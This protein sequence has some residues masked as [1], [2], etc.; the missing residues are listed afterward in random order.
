[1]IKKFK[2]YNE[3]LKDKM[4]GKSED[5]ILSKYLDADN[6]P[7]LLLDSIRNNFLRGFEVALK[8]MESNYDEELKKEWLGYALMK[9]VSF[10][11][12]DF[13]KKSIELGADVNINLG[14]PLLDACT[15][16]Y[17]KIVETLLKN[18]ANPHIRHDEAIEDCEANAYGNPDEE[19]KKEYVEILK[20]L[21]QYGGVTESLRDKMTPKS[22]E[23]V[24]TKRLEIYNE[25]VDR[26]M[27]EGYTSEKE[28]VMEFFSDRW[29]DM[30]E[31]A[32][33]GWTVEEIYNQLQ[34]DLEYWCADDDD[35]D[36]W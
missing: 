1:M 4:V 12:L 3:S 10:H 32:E 11:R 7:G 13:V 6:I 19:A 2:Q 29:D 17:V 25:L 27:T 16:G 26:G 21:K 20:L 31:M 22:D 28:V 30:I 9:A 15:M 34:M 33:E 23:Y 24:E 5:E 35:D 8:Y 14:K 36:D 18:G